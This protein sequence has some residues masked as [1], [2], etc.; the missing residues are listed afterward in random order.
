[1]FRGMKLNSS[2]KPEAGYGAGFW[3]RVGERNVGEI[4]EIIGFGYLAKNKNY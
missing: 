2:L 1:M 3:K 4:R